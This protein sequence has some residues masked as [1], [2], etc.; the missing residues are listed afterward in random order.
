M[1]GRSQVDRAGRLL[2]RLVSLVEDRQ[3]QLGQGGY[4]DLAEL[5]AAVPEGQR[6]PYVLFLL[7]R[8]DGFASTLGEVDSGRMTEQVMTLLRDGASVGLHVVV[9]GDR[10]LVT[11][12]MSTLVENRLVLRLADRADFGAVGIPVKLVP[13]TL[14][15]GRALTPDPVVEMQ[16]AVLADDI[17]GAGQNAALREIAARHAE[18][19][20]ATPGGLRP[21]RLEEL[22]AVA[23][24]DE[25][26]RQAVRAAADRIAE[27]WL[28]LGLGGDDLA[29]AGLDLSGSAVA[30]LAGPPT[31][32]RTSLLRFVAAACREARLPVL[33]LCPLPSALSRDLGA[34]AL[35]TDGLDEEAL[36]ARF[37]ELPGGTVLMVDD[38]ELLKDGPLAQALLAMVQ[39]ARG[40]GWRVLVA[41]ATAE[42][43]AGYSGWVYEARKSRQGILL[44]PQGMADG[45][46]FSARLM[47]SSLM[48]R[49]HPGRGYVVHPGG[50]QLLIQVPWVSG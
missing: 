19:D 15:D 30:V 18:R 22:P 1:V 34:D 35:V 32:G 2:S 33:A 3:H 16:V 41:G 6:P 27:G 23:P 36:V 29:L 13:D 12:R 14:V 9:S 38:A 47:R 40:K 39:Q 50:D 37:R 4:A 17:S 28:P 45:D 43:G 49:I 48:P 10:T 7:D 31:S 46:I 5:R 11:G 44:S 25:A 20:A 21:F 8:W 42:V 26:V 24:Y